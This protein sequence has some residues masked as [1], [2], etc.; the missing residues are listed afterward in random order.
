[1]EKRHLRRSTGTR[2]ITG[3]NIISLLQNKCFPFSQVPSSAPCS[4]SAHTERMRNQDANIGG[5]VQSWQETAICSELFCGI[6]I[7]NPVDQRPLHF[8]NLDDEFCFVFTRLGLFPGTRF[9]TQEIWRALPGPGACLLPCSP[10][11]RRCPACLWGGAV[12]MTTLAEYPHA[13]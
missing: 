3:D 9:P 8:L 4:I 12:V 7:C 1:M 2:L 5:S 6:C 13:C 11:P 10:A